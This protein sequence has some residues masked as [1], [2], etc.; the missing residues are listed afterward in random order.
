VTHLDRWYAALTAMHFEEPGYSRSHLDYLCALVAVGRAVDAASFLDVLTVQA[1]RSGGGWAAA[2]AHTGQALLQA[3]AGRLAEAQASIGQALTWYRNSPLRFDQARTSLIAGQINRRAKAKTA[4]YG[5]LDEARR[6]F[7]SFGAT[8]WEALA[9][10]ELAR[11]NVR[12]RAPAELT[13]T[14]RQVAE[15]V[16]TGLTNQEAAARAFMAVKTVEAVLGR[17]YRKLGIRSRAE[18][19]A[20]MHAAG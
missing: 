14:E 1:R 18:L 7:G 13:E 5:L 11:V 4:A 3:Q 19:A 20:R 2:V 10:A 6:E 9:A 15:L 16:A 12:P 17:V 8:A